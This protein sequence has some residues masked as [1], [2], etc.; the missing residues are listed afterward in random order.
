MMQQR[1]GD[2]LLRPTT[3]QPSARA[4]TIRDHGRT[5]LAY[6]EM[7]GHAHEVIPTVAD[8]DPVAAQELFEEP[9]GTRL[10]VVRRPCALRHEEHDPIALDVG[11][12]YEVIRQSEWSLDQVRR[13]AD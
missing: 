2:V 7:T 9:D 4:K 3:V 1:Q 10:L 11:M 6:G 5:I 12:T 13:V 8:P